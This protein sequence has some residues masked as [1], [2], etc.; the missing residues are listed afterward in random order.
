[1]S[2][3]TSTEQNGISSINRPVNGNHTF[4][5]DRHSTTGK[6]LAMFHVR[7]GPVDQ[8]RHSCS[9]LLHR[10]VRLFLVLSGLRAGGS[11]GIADV[12]LLVLDTCLL[13]QIV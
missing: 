9:E 8:S 7:R 2:Y 1:M 11:V 10:L 6:I 4:A 13:D 3:N 12:G 5:G